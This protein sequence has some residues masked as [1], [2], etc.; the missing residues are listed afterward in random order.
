MRTIVKPWSPKDVDTAIRLYSTGHTF[1]DIA[2]TLRRSRGEIAGKLFRLRREGRVAS[3]T[4][5]E[6]PPPREPKNPKPSPKP[7][8]V[9]PRPPQP[10]RRIKV[11]PDHRPSPPRYD[12]PKPTGPPTIW[13]LSHNQCKFPIGNRDEHGP[14]TFCG[15][16]TEGSSWCPTHHAVVY[17]RRSA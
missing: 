10:I 1:T 4:G 12:P 14:T 16:P 5:K 11:T 8:L 3:R 9:K 15:K 7:T 6:Q 2:Q 17:T 13:E